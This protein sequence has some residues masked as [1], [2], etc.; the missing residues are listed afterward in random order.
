MT[1]VETNAAGTFA[2]SCLAPD[3]AVVRMAQPETVRTRPREGQR[4]LC[5]H[6]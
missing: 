2:D 3:A 4:E 1:A 6:K 5:G